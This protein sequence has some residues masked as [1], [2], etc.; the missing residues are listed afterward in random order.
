MLYVSTRST[1]DT[2][3]AHRALHE[4]RTP[5]GGFFVPFH[6]PAYS[7]QDLIRLKK[8]S[9]CDTVAEILN[10]FFSL[11]LTGLDLE[12]AI[13]R[14]PVKSVPMNQ[15]LTVVETWRNPDG[16]FRYLLNS[17][18]HLLTGKSRASVGWSCIAIE[19]AV[20]FGMYTLL[21]DSQKEYDIA[22]TAGDFADLAAVFYAKDMGLPVNVTVCACSEGSPAWDL[23]NR[24]QFSTNT[25]V[26]VLTYIECF[27]YNCFGVT[28]VLQYLRACDRGAVC[29]FDEEQTDMLSGRMFAAVVSANRVDS[30]ISSMYRTNQY[31]IDP[32][33]AFA[34]GGLQDYRAQT[35]SNRDTLLLAKLRPESVKE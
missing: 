19:V 24:G 33:T 22:V 8:Q 11:H 34:Y 5:D 4:P 29:C 13:G 28:G 23:V 2:Y 31:H 17:I 16:S 1:A 30:V 3:T 6:L 32:Y 7:Q 14:N 12:C 21:E 20:L 15:K 27:L 26:D 35:G 9:F 18:Y 10:L 25:N